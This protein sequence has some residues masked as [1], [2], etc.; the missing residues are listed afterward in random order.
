[1]VHRSR[2]EQSR[3]SAPKVATLVW[4]IGRVLPAGQVTVPAGSSTVTSSTVNPPSTGA[5]SGF[6]LI[7]ASSASVSSIAPRR[8]PVP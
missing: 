5:R 3:H 2:R 4:L 7:M 8:S 6:G 1:M